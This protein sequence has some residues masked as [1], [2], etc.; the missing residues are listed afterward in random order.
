[1]RKTKEEIK[2]EKIYAPLHKAFSDVAYTR[3]LNGKDKRYSPILCQKK[4]MKH[5]LFP[6]IMDDLKIAEFL[7]DEKA[8]AQIPSFNIFTFIAGAILAV[9][10]FAG[11]I[12]TQGLIYDVFLQ[13]GAINDM[14]APAT[15]VHPCLD[16]SSNLCTSSSYVNLTQA[17]QITFGSVY[18]S[19]KALRM[20]AIVYILS[21]GACIILTNALIKVNPIFF[22]MFIL[23]AL[24]AVIYS[25]SISNAY[26]ALY[27]SQPFGGELNNFS[28]PNILILNL[29]LVVLIISMLGTL[30]LFINVMRVGFDTGGVGL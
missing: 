21:L 14:N 7:K 2:I 3:V 30:F 17:A 10:L 25:P 5:P 12:Y 23:I 15:S 29:P 18:E 22:F 27:Q 9:I 26:L 13:A 6:K 8:Q 1:M 16:N 20:V 4:A 28:I 19:I 24:F 11:L